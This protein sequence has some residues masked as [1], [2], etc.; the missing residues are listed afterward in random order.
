MQQVANID[1][2]GSTPGLVAFLCVWCGSTDSVLIHPIN[3]RGRSSI[4][5]IP[6]EMWCCRLNNRRR[7][8]KTERPSV[9]GLYFV[10]RASFVALGADAARLIEARYQTQLNRVVLA[11]EE[12]CGIVELAALTAERRA[13]ASRDDDRGTPL[14]QFSRELGHAIGA[15]PRRLI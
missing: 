13:A 1:A 9:S 5:L 4:T 3:G 12:T 11:Q 8:C 15:P 2:N 6:T 10:R 7:P 14:Y